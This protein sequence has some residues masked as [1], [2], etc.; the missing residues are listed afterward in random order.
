MTLFFLTSIFESFLDATSTTTGATFTYLLLHVHAA[1][2]FS[3]SSENAQPISPDNLP[4]AGNLMSDVVRG[5]LSD[6]LYTPA[7]LD[8]QRNNL[9]GTWFDVAH[10]SQPAPGYYQT[11]QD[12]TGNIMTRTV[13]RQKHL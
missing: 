9:D 5:N 6:E 12:S 11:S 10:D 1:A 13:G 8:D 7:K 4:R 3:P 2:P